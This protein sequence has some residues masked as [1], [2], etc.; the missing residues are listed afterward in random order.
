M[1]LRGPLTRP[2]QPD[3]DD[4]HPTLGRT[5][6]GSA[7]VLR[8]AATVMTCADASEGECAAV[9]IRRQRGEGT[10]RADRAARRAPDPSSA[11]GEEM[12]ETGFSSFNTTVDKTNHVL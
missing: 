9:V 12:A 10:P 5:P 1:S 2:H 6:T 3:H 8:R 7:H 11:G 4:H